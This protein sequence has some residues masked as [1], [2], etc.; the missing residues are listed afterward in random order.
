MKKLLSLVLALTMISS[1]LALVG[2]NVFGELFGTTGTQSSTTTTTTCGGDPAPVT[3]EHGDNF[4]ED[5]IE[6]VRMLHGQ[7]TGDSSGDRALYTLSEIICFAQNGYSLF[8]MHFENPY[9]ICGYLKPNE[10]KAYVRGDDGKIYLDVTKCVWYKYY[11]SE[12]IPESVDNMELKLSYLLYDCTVIKD[13][14]DNTVYNEELK[15]YLKYAYGSDFDIISSDMIMFCGFENIIEGDVKF[16]AQ[17]NAYQ[18]YEAYVDGDGVEYLFFKHRKFSSE[19]TLTNDYSEQ[20]FFSSKGDLYGKASPYFKIL[21]EVTD[22]YGN[23]I[24]YAGIKLDIL[25]G[26]EI[27]E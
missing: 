8:L 13:L 26:L 3:F 5:D 23:L 14:S 2:C 25:L 22:E 18:K 7:G 17:D 24:Q 16:L 6:F 10:E 15:Y 21:K 11:D 19:G 20:L 27:D 9:V 12:S 4:T 1:C